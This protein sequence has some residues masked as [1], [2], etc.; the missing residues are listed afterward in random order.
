VDSINL[1][2]FIKCCFFFFVQHYV[3]NAIVTLAQLVESSQ[4]RNG[5]VFKYTSGTLVSRFAVYHV[6][7]DMLLVVYKL[8]CFSLIY[9]SC[10]IALLISRTILSSSRDIDASCLV[11]LSKEMTLVFPKIVCVGNE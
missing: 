11:P 8:L 6:Q 1:S 9:A 2:N 5:D 7:G 4:P 10:L 3:S